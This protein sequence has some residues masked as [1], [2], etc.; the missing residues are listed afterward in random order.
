[1]IPLRYNMR[2]LMVRRTTS[3]MT[4]AG[5]A[6]VVLVLFIL[7]GFIAGLRNTV[8]A[9]GSRGVW[10]VLSRGV[11][12]EPASYLTREQFNIIRARNEIAEDGSGRTLISPEFVTGFFADPDKPY[13]QTQ[14]TYLRGVY[15]IAYR[16]HPNMRLVSGHWP[17]AGQSEMVVGRKLAARA[18]NLAPGRQI[19]F[20]RRVWTITGIF[21]DQN[22]ARESEV[23]TDLDVLEQD[24]RYAHGFASFHVV[25][26]LGMAE[27]FK[28]A[29][30]NDSRLIA[31][32]EPESEFYLQESEL[33]E[34]LRGFGLV[35]VL[36]LGIGASFG[37]MN[38]IVC[39]GRAPSSRGRGSAGAWFP[40]PLSDV[41]LSAR[42]RDACDCGR[43]CGRS[44]RSCHSYNDRTRQPP[45]ECRDV[46]L[47]V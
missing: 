13:A 34:Q 38:T 25:L 9:A 33:A 41:E 21:S 29:L 14:F 4:M 2:S 3:L 19:H 1:M 32:A 46:H 39:S 15:P 7:S 31:S 16:V 35:I 18:P 11:T 30:N 37:G 28:H 5:V 47:F 20:G 44:P 12:S 42:K 27:S 26:R 22:S 40:L 17:S 23:W 10:I 8:M 6:L 36:I 45:D 43:G 24:V